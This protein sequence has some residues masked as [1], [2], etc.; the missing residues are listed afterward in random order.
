MRPVLDLNDLA[1]FVRV[2]DHGGFTAAAKGLGVSKSTLSQRVARLEAELGARLLQRTSRR[3][4][5]T[6]AG[7]D[8]H[9][10]ASA[11]LAEAEAGESAVRER[12]GEPRGTVRFTC[13]LA[14]AAELGP[15]LA[16]F[17][18]QH[19]HVRL[20]QH[21]TNRFVDLVAEGFDIGVRGHDAPLADSNLI[22]RR[23]ALTPWK[24]VASPAYLAASGTP[25]KP[26]DLLRHHCLMAANHDGATVWTLRHAAHGIQRV[27][28]APRFT[29]DDQETL[30]MAALAGA[31]IAALPGYVC[32]ADIR[33]GRLLQI[34]KGWTTG[35]PQLTLLTPTRRGQ[36][37]AVRALID[38]L[39]KE[40]P[41]MIAADRS[42][43][44]S[45]RR[46]R[47][48]GR[49]D[50]SGQAT[51]RIPAR[52]R[53]AFRTLRFAAAHCPSSV[54]RTSWIA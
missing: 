28:V 1:F 52:G 33:N 36:L 21:T 11:M 47:A 45:A 34:L 20:V 7:R 9:R 38:F 27:E 44:G 23:I 4:A 41:R 51:S 24:V 39:A 31:G 49:A 50:S 3:F 30:K 42:E 48:F 46:R 32:N 15:L 8:L 13:P 16:R 14:T 40:Y 26:A 6:D 2:V 54:R 18:M 19:P 53:F 35:E 29:S 37:P 25:A 43:P 10:Y 22:A 12:L 17:L 5:V